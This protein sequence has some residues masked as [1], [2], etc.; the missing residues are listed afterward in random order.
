[1]KDDG[2]ADK[3]KRRP[4]HHRCY[5]TPVD[6]Q[7]Q[8]AGTPSSIPVSTLSPPLLSLSLSLS[9]SLCQQPAKIEAEVAYER[10]CSYE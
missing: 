8:P 6:P 2:D 10:R 7:L 9:L 4:R 3:H 5:A 1:V